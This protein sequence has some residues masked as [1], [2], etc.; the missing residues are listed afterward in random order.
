VRAG[1]GQAG[2]GQAGAA[3]AEAG[4]TGKRQTG[5]GHARAQPAPAG[6]RPWLA[7]LLERKAPKLAAVAL[8]NKM[9]RIA[10]KLMATGGTYDPSHGRSGAACAAAGAPA[11]A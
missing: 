5:K 6:P 7:R 4:Q 3:P 11:A 9:A 2:Q 1:Q 8:A 10:W